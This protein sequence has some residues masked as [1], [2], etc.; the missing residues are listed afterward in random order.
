MQIVP[1]KCCAQRSDLNLP[2]LSFSICY[3][4]YFSYRSCG[5]GQSL[6]PI[7]VHD[8]CSEQGDTLT[9]DESSR[10]ASRTNEDRAFLIEMP[11]DD[12]TIVYGGRIRRFSS[13][14]TR[15][16]GSPWP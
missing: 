6:G 12:L 8:I 1:P 2:L 11:F 10:K 14:N 13:T 7:V 5:L 15:R 9:V 4:F 16:S 3:I